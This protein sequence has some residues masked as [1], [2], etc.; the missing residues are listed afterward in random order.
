MLKRWGLFATAARTSWL[1]SVVNV[2][3]TEAGVLPFFAVSIRTKSFE[4]AASLVNVS[5]EVEK[6]CAT[7]Q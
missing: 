3:K 4:S 5:A 2:T 7:L 6:C 1:R